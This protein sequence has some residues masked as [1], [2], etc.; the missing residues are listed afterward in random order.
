MKKLIGCV[1]ITLLWVNPAFSSTAKSVV[2]SQA[3]SP[4]KPC[5]QNNTYRDFDFWL[6]EWDV[7]GNY[8]KTGVNFGHNS[9]TQ[10]ESGCLIMEHWRGVKGS[11]GTSMNYYDG[12]VNQW[13]Q[14]WVSAGGTVID[15]SGG[16]IASEGV[17][18]DKGSKAMRLEGKIYYASSQQQPQIRDF[19]GTWTPLKKGVVRQLFE[20]STD[21]GKTWTVWFDGY[22]F[23]T[24]GENE[25]EK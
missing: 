24:K 17:H 11:T 3:A 1:C 7:Y 9:I 22:Y 15:Y 13:V 2:N 21:A 23:P 4:P 8:E 20:E 14:R 5:M 19:R 12:I 10:S 16:L 6:G 18:A 25:N